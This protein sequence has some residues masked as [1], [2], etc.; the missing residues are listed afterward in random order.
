[1]PAIEIRRLARFA[2]VLGV[3]A[4]ANVAWES[5]AVSNLSVAFAL[6]RRYA[7]QA[8][9]ALGAVSLLAP[10]RAERVRG[11]ARRPGLG[12]VEAGRSGERE[13][14]SAWIHEVLAPLVEGD[15]DRAPL[16]AEGALL[17]LRAAARCARRDRSELGLSEQD[18]HGSGPGSPPL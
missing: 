5:L 13:E 18:S 14:T 11:V 6:N 1:A 2:R 8:V 7:W 15:A 16:L 17:R 10:L 9:G 12:P 3:D 4:E